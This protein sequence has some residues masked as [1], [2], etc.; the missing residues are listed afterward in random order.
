MKDNRILKYAKRKIAKFNRIGLHYNLVAKKVYRKRRSRVGP[1]SQSFMQYIIAGLISFD[2]G[3]MMGKDEDKYKIEDNGFGSR[4]NPKLR[5]IKKTLTPLMDL[6]LTEIGLQQHNDAIVKAYN[7]L[8]A[9]GKGALNANPKKHFY[10]GATKILH[11]L[12]PKLFIIVDSNAAEAFREA[13]NVEF[14]KGTQPGYSA[15]RYIE[16]MECAQSDIL[17]YNR[18]HPEGFEALEWDTPITRIYD[19]LT[20]ITG[21]D[22]KQERQK[23]ANA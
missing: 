13:H 1:F 21:M 23:R 5:A 11:F 4:L 10:V 15:K 18:A 9:N 17:K 6:R 3:R 19:K 7:T 20:F 12:N 8:S 16:C 2:I 14:G 22:I